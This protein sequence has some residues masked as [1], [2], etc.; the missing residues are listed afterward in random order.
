MVKQELACF[1]SKRRSTK[2]LKDLSLTNC[3]YVRCNEMAAKATDVVKTKTLKII[4]EQFEKTWYYW[5]EGIR[6]WCISR[7]LWWGHRV[8]AY[9]VKVKV[10][11]FVR[12]ISKNLLWNRFLTGAL[13]KYLK[14]QP[15]FDPTDNKS[16][17]SGRTEEEAL[18]KAAKTLGIKD[19][20]Q[21]T[22]K[23]VI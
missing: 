15:D 9:L 4:P 21:I 12:S 10:N 11:M 22:L 6:D 7:Q 3:R 2:M 23:Q 17:V 20:S 5:M 1:Q 13:F 14:G 8:P 16:W 18:R 19:T